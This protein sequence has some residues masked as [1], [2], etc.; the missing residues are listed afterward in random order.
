LI[1]RQSGC[2]FLT[3]LFD[4]Q[5]QTTG[6]SA[7]VYGRSISGVGAEGV[8]PARSQAVAEEF[9]DELIQRAKNLKNQGL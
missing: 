9:R 2:S 1:L 4:L 7:V 6:S 8:L 3:L 5:I